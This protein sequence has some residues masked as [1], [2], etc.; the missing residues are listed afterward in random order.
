MNDQERQAE[1][2]RLDMTLEE[3]EKQLLISDK[4]CYTQEAELRASLQSYWDL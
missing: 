4:D 2:R 3:I 1:L